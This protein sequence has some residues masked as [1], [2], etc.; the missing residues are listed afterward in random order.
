MRYQSSNSSVRL[1]TTDQLSPIVE[2]SGEREISSLR[3]YMNE[4]RHT[5][6]CE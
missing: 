3:T 6:A 2:L 1:R 4:K 5:L